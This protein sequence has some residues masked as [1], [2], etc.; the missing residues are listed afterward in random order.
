[1]CFSAEKRSAAHWTAEA[2][3]PDNISHPPGEE[4]KKQ[5]AQ[6]TV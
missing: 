2:Q 5:E 4:S 3:T 1:M 6:V